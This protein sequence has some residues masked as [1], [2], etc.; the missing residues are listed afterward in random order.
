MGLTPHWQEEPKA[1]YIVTTFAPSQE[2]K[3]KP[4]RPLEDLKME[5]VAWSTDPE[6]RSRGDCGVF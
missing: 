4:L 2:E 6:R 3:T 1:L 5:R